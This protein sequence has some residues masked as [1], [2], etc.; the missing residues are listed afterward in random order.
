MKSP[1]LYSILK[2]NLKNFIDSEKETIIKEDKKV[3][4]NKYY[5]NNNIKL[6]KKEEELY[7]IKQQYNH[8][9][10]IIK[11]NKVIED[12]YIRDV[13]FID[14]S[15][16]SNYQ[17]ELDG[18]LRKGVIVNNKEYKYWG[19]SASMSRGGILGLLSVEMYELV[20][21]YAMME[22]TFDKTI[23][24]KFEAY[25]CLLLSSCFCIE[26]DLPYMIVVDD[27]NTVVKDVN[28]RY[29]AEKDVNYTDKKTNE[30]KVFK[31]KIIKA[32]IMDI[33]NCTNDGSGLMDITY[34][35]KISEYLQIGYNA[36]IAMLRIPYVKGL[37]IS[38][39]FK[40][41]YRLKGIT[42]LK[43]IWGKE[44][45]VDD[46]DIILTKS[47][48]KGYKYFKQDGTYKDWERYLGLLKK[49][50]Y[51][52]GIS[53]LNYSHRQEPKMTRANYQTLQT[54]DIAKEDLIE[55]SSYTRNWIEK[56]LGGDLL[57]IYKYLGIGEDTEPTNNYMKTT[58]LNPQMVND[59]K[60]R[61]YLYGLL[62]K[63]IDEIK[64]GKT[65]I[66]GAFKFLIPDVIMMLEY[67]GELPVKGC[68]NKG[69]MYAK[70]HTGEYILNRNPHISRAEHV[71]LTATCNK[72]IE[73]WLSHL[74]NVCMVN[75]YDV[76]AQS[77]NGA[78]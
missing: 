20:E 41:Y 69:E 25:K 46:I 51:C 60:V 40:T 74:A 23:L 64:I 2:L 18:I 37:A 59:I 52:V 44:H 27:Y 26:E 31:E 9:F 57:Y 17:K 50:N 5:L 12:N 66:K 4:K 56:I 28:I 48:Y 34:A 22:I 55:M 15:N 43:D 49:Y 7:T 10:R 76:T 3:T 62:K 30:P 47:Q 6:N 77:L 14:C 68:L 42:H 65:H 19:K 33:D 45:K 1:E 71:I 29:V 36:C 67:I 16:S 39:D 32:G 11:N 58:L 78:D 38:V 13:L 21:S 53:K 75:G 61:S 63:T 54:L 72:Q 35:K 8:L 70:A 73:Q 24:S